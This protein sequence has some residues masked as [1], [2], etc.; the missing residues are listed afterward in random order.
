MM[1]NRDLSVNMFC[2]SIHPP[3]RESSLASPC[4]TR[5]F[6]SF[7]GELVEGG[8]KP[9]MCDRT[10]R[11]E[12][13]GCVVAPLIMAT[14]KPSERRDLLLKSRCVKLYSRLQRSRLVSQL[15]QSKTVYMVKALPD[16]LLLWKKVCFTI[17][18]ICTKNVYQKKRKGSVF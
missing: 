3:I 1:E 17:L 10:H 12:V 11:Q 7:Y 2:T 6:Q 9:L 14:P 18:S 4:L 5:Q 13:D 8:K 15:K 16:K